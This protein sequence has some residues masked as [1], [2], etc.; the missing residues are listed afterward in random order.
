MVTMSGD[1][2]VQANFAERLFTLEVSVD[3]PLFGTVMLSPPGGVYPQG[4]VV[5]LNALPDSGGEFLGWTGTDVGDLADSSAAVTS[6]TMDSSKTVVAQFMASQ[7]S[8]FTLTATSNP[9]NGGSVGL[10]P[11][12][13]TYDTGTTVTLTA[14]P[15]NGFAFVNW[16]GADAEALSSTTN[17]ETTITISADRMVQANFAELTMF[18]LETLTS[19]PGN[20]TLDPPGGT[21]MDG[22]TV[23]LTATPTGR[24]RFDAWTG[25]N[26]GEF[27][28]GNEST[29]IV[30]IAM[31][32]NKSVTANFVDRGEL[33]ATVSGDGSVA[34]DPAGPVYDVGTTVTVTATPNTGSRFERYSGTDAGELSDASV[35][36]TTIEI[37]GD[38]SITAEFGVIPSFTV[39]AGVNPV[40]AGMVTIAPDQASYT[41][42]T[43]VTITA[44]PGANRDFVDWSSDQITAPQRTENP[45]TLTVASNTIITA[46]FSEPDCDSVPN[47][48]FVSENRGSDQTGDGTTA[49]PFASI[50]FALDKVRDCA[51]MGESFTLR[52]EEGDYPE[53]LDLPPMVTL[54]GLGAETGDVQ[55]RPSRTQLNDDN[56]A[57]VMASGNAMTNMTLRLPID[58][59]VGSTL[60]FVSNVSVTLEDCELNGS[61]VSGSVGINILSRGSDNTTVTRCVMRRLNDGIRA[62]ESRANITRN[63]FEFI[64]ND[65][66]FVSNP[67][68]KQASVTPLLGD[69]SRP[70][71]T[72][73][74]VFRSVTRT[75]VRNQT[76]IEMQA[77]NNDW[78]A[79]TEADA[80]AAKM[81]GPIDFEP[82]IGQQIDPKNG[83]MGCSPSSGERGGVAEFL[84]VW[85]ALGLLAMAHVLRIQGPA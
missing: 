32:G 2:T 20:V 50:G 38:A 82:F 23:T 56:R 69:A 76:P 48:L 64:N 34:L 62:V 10:T 70:N 31:D 52:I 42:G 24:A 9:G 54:E 72:G 45:L 44:R 28:L 41:E 27:S 71:D 57:I 19:G 79:L 75:F 81:A 6:I 47:P 25:A 74:N 84:V 35:A 8:Q 46:N 22:V 67:P 60:V 39:T 17:E 68:N 30:T 77:E 85:I 78:E 73:N 29:P 4:T 65:A 55:I 18:S 37:V 53:R 33:A 63:Q 15:A 80:V 58:A 59:P 36:M 7:T 43:V 61:D 21:Y 16:S 13:G 1:R 49:A 5:T 11:S 14:T 40:D 66:L 51:E 3:A 26:A 83:A 12:G